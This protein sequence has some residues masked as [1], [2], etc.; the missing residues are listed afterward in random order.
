M[1]Q[2]AEILDFLQKGYS[3]TGLDG[4]NLFGTM[5]LRNRIGELRREGYKIVGETVVNEN[6]K[7]YSRYKLEQ[8]A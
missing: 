7:R 3:L 1:S 4:L 2:K 6:G 5:N 8:G